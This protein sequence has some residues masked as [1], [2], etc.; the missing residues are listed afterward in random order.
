MNTNTE[1][2][3]A[4][5]ATAAPRA[6][7]PQRFGALKSLDIK[8]GRNGE[9]GILT[10][11][12]GGKFEQVA[13]IFNA[14]VLKKARDAASKAHAAGKVAQVWFKGPIESVEKGG[15][16]KDEMK[17][18]YFK[19]N[20]D[21]ADGEGDAPEAAEEAAADDLTV[22]KGIGATVAT[23][24]TE[25]GVASFAALAAQTPEGLDALV[26]G[27]GARATRYDW[28]GQ[29]QAAVAA[30]ATTAP[31]ATRDLDDEIPF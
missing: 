25:A 5:T 3:T 19:D 20:T 8:S 13:F 27:Y 14:E 18:V 29:A 6:N 30:A 12:C 22:L 4:S 11:N 15:F 28:V 2:N 24:L 26:A 7:W 23:A 1:T 9:Y 16:K 21:Y 31:A 10:I 17:I